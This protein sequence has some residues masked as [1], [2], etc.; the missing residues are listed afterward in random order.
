MFH[1][2][3]L[4]VSAKGILSD[5]LSEASL[6]LQADSPVSQEMLFLAHV[7]KKESEDSSILNFKVQ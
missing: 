7:I 4:S 6:N 3:Q 1:H 2:H 5:E